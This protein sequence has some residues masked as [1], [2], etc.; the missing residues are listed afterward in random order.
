MEKRVREAKNSLHTRNKLS[1][2]GGK[3]R[4]IRLSG[5]TMPKERGTEERGTIPK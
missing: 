2:T 1:V 3:A 5:W 4:N